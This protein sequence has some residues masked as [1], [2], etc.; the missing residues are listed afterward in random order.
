MSHQVNDPYLDTNRAILCVE[1]ILDH[2]GKRR[3]VITDLHSHFHMK[4][5]TTKEMMMLFNTYKDNIRK[6][7]ERKTKA[8]DNLKKEGEEARHLTL[9]S[10]SSNYIMSLMNERIGLRYIKS[11]SIFKLRLNC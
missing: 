1:N 11:L 7:G 5:T 2:M 6:V 10:V 3:L 8:F 9:I 4:L